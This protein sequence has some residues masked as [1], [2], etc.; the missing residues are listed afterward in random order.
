MPLGSTAALRRHQH[1]APHR[2]PRLQAPSPLQDGCGSGR[3]PTR[4]RSLSPSCCWQ[5]SCTELGSRTP[6]SGAQRS[7][8]SKFLRAR[9][10]TWSSRCTGLA[11]PAAR[12]LHRE[13]HGEETPRLGLGCCLGSSGV[14]AWPEDRSRHKQGIQRRLQLAGATNEVCHMLGV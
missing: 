5:R 3:A 1:R 9:K 11:P 10:E 13:Q 4:P 7:G 12:G 6:S 14:S 8:K 2:G